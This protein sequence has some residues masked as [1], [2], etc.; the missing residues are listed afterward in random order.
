MGTT[1]DGD[2]PGRRRWFRKWRRRRTG[3]RYGTCT[4]TSSE[5]GRT[6][7]P[8]PGHATDGRPG[9]CRMCRDRRQTYTHRPPPRPSQFGG[10][11]DISLTNVIDLALSHDFDR[12]CGLGTPECRKVLD[13]TGTDTVP[14]A[15][16]KFVSVTTVPNRETSPGTWAPGGV[17]FLLCGLDGKNRAYHSPD[18]RFRQPSRKWPCGRGTGLLGQPHNRFSRR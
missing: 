1:A 12:L 9:C 18:A 7:A 16:P 11:E 2:R 15:P 13:A 17:L 14:A 5:T 4:T 10:S 3:G 6:Q 8:S